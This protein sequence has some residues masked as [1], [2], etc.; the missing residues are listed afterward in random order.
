MDSRDFVDG[1]VRD[2]TERQHHRDRER[3]IPDGDAGELP[4]FVVRHWLNF[5]VYYERA[6]VTFIGGWLRT[7]R[8][9][10]AVVHLAHQVEDEANHYMW[11]GR[12]LTEL[13]GNL[14]SFEPPQPWRSLMDD[15]YPGLEHLVDRLAA[16]NIASET[17]ALGFMEFNL[18]RFPVGIRG[19]VESVIADEKYHLAFGRTLLEKYCT[20]PEL[21]ARATRAAGEAIDRMRAARE[22]FVQI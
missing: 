7:T 16:H 8:E 6:A 11:L 17:G 9:A 20:T 18:S 12:H 1:L 10:D 19:T 13:G 2:V 5:A 21:Q 3:R 22:T 15:Y 14:S 4:D